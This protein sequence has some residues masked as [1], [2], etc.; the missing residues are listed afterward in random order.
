[1]IEHYDIKQYGS[2]LPTEVRCRLA[3]GLKLD[4]N[5]WCALPGHTPPADA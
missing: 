1:M 5:T 3:S 2:C 4:M